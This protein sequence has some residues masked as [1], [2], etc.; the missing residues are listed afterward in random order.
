MGNGSGDESDHL[1]GTRRSS[2][3][4]LQLSPTLAEETA[5]A[6][7]SANNVGQRI[8]DTQTGQI[9]VNA[10]TENDFQ[11]NT[12]NSIV[13]RNLPKR[14]KKSADDDDPIIRIIHRKK[15]CRILKFDYFRDF[16]V[17]F[18]VALMSLLI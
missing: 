10:S 14:F 13:I 15:L 2:K 11:G 6:G 8:D 9:Q 18:C 12:A 17:L 16:Y 7:H 1:A 5:D 4:R 3:K